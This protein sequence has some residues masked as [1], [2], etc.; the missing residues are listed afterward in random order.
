MKKTYNSI[1]VQDQRTLEAWYILCCD[2]ETSNVFQRK[3]YHADT[4]FKRFGYDL[5]CGKVTFVH[6]QEQTYLQT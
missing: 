4:N 1:L 6:D 2:V 5:K 3:R